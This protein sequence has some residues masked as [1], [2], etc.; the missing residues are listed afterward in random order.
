MR[1]NWILCQT[2]LLHTYPCH[3]YQTRVYGENRR[4]H[5]MLIAARHIVSRYMGY[6]YMIQFQKGMSFEVKNSIWHV[7]L[8]DKGIFF[9]WGIIL[10]V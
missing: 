2:H 5:V 8:N 9:P 10:H 3:K 6:S 1:L 4:V 7:S